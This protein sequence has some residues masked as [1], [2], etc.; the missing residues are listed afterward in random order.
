MVFSTSPAPRFV[1]ITSPTSHH[2]GVNIPPVN[3][4]VAWG[5]VSSRKGADILIALVIW[6]LYLPTQCMNY[7]SFHKDV[8]NQVRWD[9]SQ[10]ITM[11]SIRIFQVQADREWLWGLAEKG[12]RAKLSPRMNLEAELFYK[13]AEDSSRKWWYL[14]R[15][16][17]LCSEPITRS[18]IGRTI[19]L[20]VCYHQRRRRWGIAIAER[21]LCS[22]TLLGLQVSALAGLILPLACF[23]A[24]IFELAVAVSSLRF[25]VL[26]THI[27]HWYIYFYDFCA[28]RS[29]ISLNICARHW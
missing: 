4:S 11:P 2:E 3:G 15:P 22:C 18:R 25:S 13:S 12:D 5:G 17:S 16:I 21:W 6:P 1:F 29:I 28:L 20:M 26:L 27:I 8:M 9:R 23:F 10:E 7:G 14:I 19:I 24:S